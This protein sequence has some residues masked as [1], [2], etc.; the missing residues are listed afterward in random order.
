MRQGVLPYQRNA[1]AF[2]ASTPLASIPLSSVQPTESH[3]FVLMID[4][5]SFHDSLQGNGSWF[6]LKSLLRLELAVPTQEHGNEQ[7]RFRS[8]WLMADLV[9]P[10]EPAAKKEHPSC[11]LVPTVPRGNAY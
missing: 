1:A 3:G 5:D 7:K 6:F 4:L 2:L 8:R 9:P 11:P 10:G